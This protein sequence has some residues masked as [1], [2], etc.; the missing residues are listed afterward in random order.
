[1]AS[2]GEGLDMAVQGAFTCPIPKSAGAQMR[3]LVR[4]HQ[5][6]T[7]RVAEL[8]G[9]SQRDSTTTRFVTGPRGTGTSPSPCSLAL[10]FLTVVAAGSA[11]ERP[12]QPAHLTRG[13]PPIR[14]T[15]P[16]IR[17]L[18]AAV[19]NPPTV[20]AAKLLHWSGWRRQHQAAARRSHSDGAPATNRRD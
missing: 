20:S 19:F 8:L 13:H 12:A 1:M 6:S 18:F 5:R 14:L 3:Y 7:R 11:P 15:V 4:Q 2:P 9:T 16:E 17:H 10:A